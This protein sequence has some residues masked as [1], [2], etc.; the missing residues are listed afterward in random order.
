ML[1]RSG[2]IR[3]LTHC[4]HIALSTYTSLKLRAATTLPTIIQAG[5][6]CPGGP[7]ARLPAVALQDEET[8][9]QH[10][11]GPSVRV[12]AVA[13]WFLYDIRIVDTPNV[14]ADVFLQLHN[15]T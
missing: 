14:M 6:R 4:K 10:S 8:L 1:R 2:V 3:V 9:S 12:P 11:V 5:V 7:D 15:V 13:H